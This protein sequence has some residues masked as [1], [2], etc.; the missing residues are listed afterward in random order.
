MS[1]DIVNKIANLINENGDLAFDK[2]PVSHSQVMSQLFLHGWDFNQSADAALKALDELVIKY[3]LAPH[4]VAATK[5]DIIQN[6]RNWQ[7]QGYWSPM[8]IDTW[9]NQP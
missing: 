1:D 6:Y 9:T 4:V 8:D 5:E 2:A 7:H 3:D